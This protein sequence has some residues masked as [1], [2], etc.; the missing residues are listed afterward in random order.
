MQS[1]GPPVSPVNV[2]AHNNDSVWIWNIAQNCSAIIAVEVGAF[3]REN[4]SV[5]PVETTLDFIDSK[6][7]WPLDIALNNNAPGK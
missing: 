3:D 1:L 6:T 7:V 2:L 4:L 5:V